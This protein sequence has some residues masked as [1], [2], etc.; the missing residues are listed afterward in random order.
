MISPQDKTAFFYIGEERRVEPVCEMDWTLLSDPESLRR[1]LDA[2]REIIGATDLDVAATYFASLLGSVC[3][4]FHYEWAAEGTE[5]RF[6]EEPA[7]LQLL[8]SGSRIPILAVL[9]ASSRKRIVPGDD[10]GTER[11]RLAAFYERTI[12]PIVDTAA[13]VSG[14]RVRNLW[15]LLASRVRDVEE[16]L[17]DTAAPESALRFDRHFRLLREEISPD[18]LGLRSNPFAFEVRMVED[19]ERPGTFYRQ[20]PACCLAYKVGTYGYCVTCPRLPSKQE[21]HSP[22]PKL[23]SGSPK[24]ESGNQA[25]GASG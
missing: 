11:D 9:P 19:P 24:S 13:Q 5:L 14:E 16:R 2:Y 18:L 6:G 21:A 25:A 23:S 22:N 1:F 10:A 17:K 3:A 4:G 8:P 12:R 20:R 15:L 7:V